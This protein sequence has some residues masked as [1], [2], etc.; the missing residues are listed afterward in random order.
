MSITCSRNTWTQRPTVLRALLAVMVCTGP[1]SAAAAQTAG[2]GASTPTDPAAP[3][4]SEDPATESAPEPA[5]AEESVFPRYGLS[6]ALQGSHAFGGYAAAEGLG[7][8][9]AALFISND[10]LVLAELGVS[11]WPDGLRVY[12]SAQDAAYPHRN[13]EFF[14]G[15]SIYPFDLSPVHLGFFLTL[16]L[17]SMSATQAERAALGAAVLWSIGERCGLRYQLGFAAHTN[18][19]DTALV[20][21]LAVDV[22]LF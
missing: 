16:T 18:F 14:V 1:A 7:F 15:A 10:P 3:T 8:S 21:S 5:P 19:V 6:L 12:R 13:W 4:Y 20:S 22:V 11:M 17:A 2:S 9:A